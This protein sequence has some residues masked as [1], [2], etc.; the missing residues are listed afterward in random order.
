MK[1]N[2]RQG[3]RSG[4]TAIRLAM[5]A[6]VIMFAGAAVPAQAQTPTLLY[7]FPGF[8]GDAC[9]T[10]GNIVQGRDGNMYGG[11]A[12]A[13]APAAARSTRFLRLEWRAP[14]SSSRSNGSIVVALG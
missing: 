7:N 14:F 2:H 6:A 13:A 12:A 4:M 8:N 11:G 3:R 9:A 5:L 1:S 10:R